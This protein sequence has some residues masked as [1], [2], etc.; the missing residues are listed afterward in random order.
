MLHVAENGVT[1]DVYRQDLLNAESGLPRVLVACPTYLGKH[2]ALEAYLS[3]YKAFTYPE[4]S[5]FMVDNT[6]TGLR[7]YEHLKSLNVPCEHI[8]PSRDWQETFARS[9]QKIWKQAELGGFRWVASIEA[10]NICPPLTIDALLNVACYCRAVH[11]AHAYDWHRSKMG[12]LIGLGCNLIST[13]LLREVFTKEKWMSDAFEA[14]VYEHPKH[15]G[16]PTVELYN[17]LDVRHLDDDVSAESYIFER[18]AIPEMTQGTTSERV[19][20]TL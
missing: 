9:W 18:E 17:L 10:D 11:V 7:Y 13:D 1:P 12:T 16:Y 20:V 15:Q 19:P 2:Y 6:G 14:E 5:L 3:A 8:D 4:K